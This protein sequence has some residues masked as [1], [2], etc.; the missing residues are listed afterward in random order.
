VVDAGITRAVVAV[1]DPN[2]LVNG[3]GLAYLR[4]AG[5]EVHT[6][7]LSHEARRLNGPFFSLMRRRRPFVT[8]KAAVSRDGGIAAAPGVRTPLTGAAANRF[9][10]RDRAETD[11]L[12]VGSGTVLADDPLLTARGAFRRRP[13]TRILFDSRLRTPVAAKLLSTLSAGPVIIVSTPAAVQSEGP[14]AAALTAAGAELLLLPDGVG[15]DAVL[16]ALAARAVSSITVEGGAA[17]HR[18]FWDAGLVDRVQMFRTPHVLGRQALEW[19]LFSMIPD[20]LSDVVT[21]PLGDDVLT[22]GYVHRD[23]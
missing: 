10:H 22:E 2:P 23:H 5:V 13:L 17:L 7:V 18:A 21:L 15:L 3:A 16:E 12:A 20:A 14:R 19:P 8:L 11:A 6:G 1:E 9:I 4:A